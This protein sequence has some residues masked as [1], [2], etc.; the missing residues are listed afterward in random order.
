MGTDYI[1]YL[2]FDQ[3]IGLLNMSHTQLAKVMGVSRPT[4]STYKKQPELVTAKIAD[5]LYNHLVFVKAQILLTEGD[6]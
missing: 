6:I 5:K 3:C 2:I 4:V 1:K